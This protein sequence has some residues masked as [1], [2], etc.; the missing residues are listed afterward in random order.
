MLQ[1][2]ILDRGSIAPCRSLADDRLRHGK[3]WSCCC[4]NET[5]NTLREVYRSHHCNRAAIGRSHHMGLLDAHGG[6]EVHAVLREIVNGIRRLALD[7]KSVVEGK[8]GSVRLDLG[9]PC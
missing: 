8:S 6:K 4:K 1:R 9:G 3:T 2:K 5:L 7:R